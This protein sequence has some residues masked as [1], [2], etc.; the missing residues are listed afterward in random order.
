MVKGWS[1]RCCGNGWSVTCMRSE[2]SGIFTDPTEF[3]ECMKVYF[4]NVQFDTPI[5]QLNILSHPNA[6][7]V[8]AVLPI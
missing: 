4:T 3:L 1:L 5:E 7:V 8:V 6:S 2:N